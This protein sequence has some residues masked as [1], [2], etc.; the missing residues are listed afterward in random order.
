[1]TQTLAV[2]ANAYRRLRS[3]A[4]FWVVL[5]ISGLVVAIFGAI[6]IN[7]RGVQLLFWNIGIVTSD[8][9]P[10]A[11]LYTMLFSQFGV[12]LWLS[13]VAAILALISTAGI[14]PHLMESG[15]IDLLLARPI[16]RARLFLT[17]YAGGLLFVTLQVGIFCLASFL[18]MGLRGGVWRPGVFLAVPLVVCF[19]SYLFALCA[20][21]GV[22]TRS[23]LAA[24]LLT[25]VAWFLVYG[26]AAAEQGVILFQSQARQEAAALAAQIED[27][28]DA[29]AEADRDAEEPP[30]R[31]GWFR[32]PESV[33][34][35]EARRRDRLDTAERLQGP[36]SILHGVLT[37]LPKTGETVNL[38]HRA[39][40]PVRE[41]GEAEVP[42]E[43]M[44]IH[45]GRN[46]AWVLGTSL[47][48]E[49]AV[50]ALAAWR[51]QRRDF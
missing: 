21:L 45:R 37:V 50:L 8:E 29:E 46:P 42:A 3:G 39:V 23:T 6:G 13:W 14:F 2:F 10:P 27:A 7:E 36:R 17:E 25:L 11:A 12:G 5:G 30:A 47:G 24:L 44:E 31:P 40:G 16:R 26:V 41:T 51:F 19:F 15:R 35:M 18:V 34:S 33:E 1:M 9:M 48:F 32:R 38:M 43:L 20:L 22:L 4:M 49:A 28:T